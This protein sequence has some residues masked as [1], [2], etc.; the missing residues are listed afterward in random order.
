MKCFA[1][2]SANLQNLAAVEA[3][4]EEA[5]LQ[6][7][8]REAKEETKNVCDKPYKRKREVDE[9]QAQFAPEVVLKRRKILVLDGKSCFGKTECALSLVPPGKSVE[10][11]CANCSMEPPLQDCPSPRFYRRTHERI[12]CGRARKK[13]W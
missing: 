3:A 2:A 7:L 11:N 5:D 10:I 12:D 6:R 9:F 13:C 4:T 1:G 8:V